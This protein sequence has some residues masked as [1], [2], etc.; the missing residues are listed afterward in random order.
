MN[1]PAETP[2][3]LGGHS[4][5]SQLGNDRAASEEEQLRIVQSCLEN[6]VRWFDTTYQP[7]RVALGKALDVLRKRSE[8]TILAWN[9][10]TNFSAVD[11]VTGADYYR[12]EH[13]EMILDE[14]HTSYVDCLVMLPLDNPA[15]NQRQEKLLVEWQ[16]KGYVRFLGLWI[17]DPQL[18]VIRHRK[19][20]RFAI[21]PFNIRTPNASSTFAAYKRLGWETIATS[22][23]V[24]GWELDRSIAKAS[25]RGYGDVEG[26]RPKLA[27]L[28]LRFSL[29]HSNADRVI[30]AMRKLEWVSA[31]VASVSKGALTRDELLWLD[32]LCRVS[33]N[34]L[35]NRVRRV[36]CPLHKV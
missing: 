9:F 17:S 25:L 3:I 21:R 11:P 24:R 16:R 6:G 36:L 32:S 10:F 12:A 30:V 26:L 31:N 35:W 20:F 23:F 33:S 1:R 14:L 15:E 7:E 18:G 4:F 27:D 22:P 28:M 13:I 29:F 19:P 34:T 5:I 2:L 8:A